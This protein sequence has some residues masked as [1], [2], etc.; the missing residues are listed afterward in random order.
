MTNTPMFAQASKPGPAHQRLAVFIGKWMNKGQVVST[1]NAPSIEILT[2]DVYEWMPGGYFVF[3]TAYGRI[4]NLDVGGVEIIGYDPTTQRYF[5]RFF[6]SS[7]QVHEAD[8]IVDSN[9]WT[10]KGKNTGCT[11]VFSENGKVQTARHRRLDETGNWV[12][13]MEVVLTKVI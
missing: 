12:P 4:G 2:S 13:A 1:A 8:L 5:S 6:D 11:A 3:H 7:G 10:W 9:T